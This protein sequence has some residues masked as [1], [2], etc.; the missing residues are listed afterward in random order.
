MERRKKSLTLA[1]F[2]SNSLLIS[3]P[4]PIAAPVT[5]ATLL[6]TSIIISRTVTRQ[7]SNT[8]MTSSED[9]TTYI[10]CARND[11]NK[12]LISQTNKYFSSL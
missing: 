6:L 8:Y 2:F 7:E 3:N 11:F 4:I 12:F 9:V 5:R 10:D 1:S